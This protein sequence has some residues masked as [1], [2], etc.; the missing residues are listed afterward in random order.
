MYT[1][2][3]A[4]T[5]IPI[6]ILVLLFMFTA[7]KKYVAGPQGDPGTPGKAGNLTQININ[8]IKV[9]TFS[10][11]FKSNTF[12]WET[13]I[14]VGEISKDVIEKGEVKVYLDLN[15]QWNALP[16]GKNYIFTQYSISENLI[17]LNTSHIHGGEPS[18]PLDANYRIVIFSPAQ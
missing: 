8:P 17:K 13:T 5:I 4:R 7:C 14:Y 15:D 18:R 1:I 6:S 3:S 10:W 11:T 2:R 9:S 16:Y 12:S